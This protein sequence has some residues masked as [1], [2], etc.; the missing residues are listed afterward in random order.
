MDET[1]SGSTGSNGHDPATNPASTGGSAD[2]TFGWTA[3]DDE[4]AAAG[5]DA[6]A[7]AV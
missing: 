4:T 5:G 3:P 1:Q 2:E 6:R 7:T